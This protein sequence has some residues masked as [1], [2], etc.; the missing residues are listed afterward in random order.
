[1]TSQMSFQQSFIRSVLANLRYPE[2][3]IRTYICIR[4]KIFQ[5]RQIKP[6]FTAFV[7]RSKLMFVKEKSIR[8][9]S[10]KNQVLKNKRDVYKKRLKII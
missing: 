10:Y 5:T 3:N 7:F 4:Y 1:M 9:M 2:F 8:R 6:L